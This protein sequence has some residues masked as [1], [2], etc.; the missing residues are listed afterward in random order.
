MTTCE[1]AEAPPAVAKEEGEDK[2]E[3]MVETAPEASEL[4]AEVGKVIEQDMERGLPPQADRRENEEPGEKAEGQS[5]VEKGSGDAGDK[6]E[7]SGALEL[8]Q[9]RQE[10]EMGNGECQKQKEKQGGSDE[11]AKEKAEK[12]ERAKSE[13]AEKKRGGLEQAQDSQANT[14]VEKA[15]A[16]KD[17]VVSTDTKPK[18]SVGDVVCVVS[19]MF[20]GSNKPGGVGRITACHPDGTY[21]VKYV[22]GGGEKNVPEMYVNENQEP[23]VCKNTDSV[24]EENRIQRRRSAASARETAQKPETSQGVAVCVP[25]TNPVDAESNQ[26][27]ADPKPSVSKV[28]VPGDNNAVVSS[29]KK[30]GG[31]G[32]K[33]ESKLN[34]GDVVQVA[35]RTWPGMNKPGGTAKITKCHQDGTFDVKYV[36]GGSEKR[37]EEQYISSTSQSKR[38]RAQKPVVLY[39]EEF[40]GTVDTAEDGQS[41]KAQSEKAPAMKKQKTGTTSDKKKAFLRSENARPKIQV[42]QHQFSLGQAVLDK[43]NGFSTL[44]VTGLLID[45]SYMVQSNPSDPWER[46]LAHQLADWQHGADTCA[47]S[48]L[49]V[50]SNAIQDGIKETSFNRNRVRAPQ[51]PSTSQQ[52]TVAV[53]NDSPPLLDVV[54]VLNKNDP[55][56]VAEM[57]LF[58]K[59]TSTILHKEAVDDMMSVST[60]YKSLKTLYSGTPNEAPSFQQFEENL[61]ILDKENK[62]M[63]S[64]GSIF[65]V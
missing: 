32:K 3:A 2:P 49:L 19:R 21:N 56:K 4:K 57:A 22:L 1:A 61:K 58:R 27:R 41:E 53:D 6:V 12:V 45:G 24:E 43:E 48:T 44:V 14:S 25:S 62:I 16:Q 37:V 26:E 38:R 46:K 11:K 39:G 42:K 17:E 52:S 9:E 8:P 5:T 63:V 33:F 10:E 18:W 20:P 15:C 55:K 59:L 64:D 65:L 51:V 7:L 36:I 54:K 13:E 40:G 29:D 23:S 30:G 47:P 50:N 35:S 28:V 34:V 60:M 31:E